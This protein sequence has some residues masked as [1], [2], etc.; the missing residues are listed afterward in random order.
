MTNKK[1]IVALVAV[2]IIAIIGV[3][4][5]QGKTVVREI[6]EVAV[7]GVSTLD[8]INHPFVKINGKSEYYYFQNMLATSSVI[9]SIRNPFSATSTL[10]RFAFQITANGLGA[11]TVDLSTSSTAFASSSPAYIRAFATGAGQSSAVWGMGAT[12]TNTSLI[13][14]AVSNNVGNS[15]NLIGPNDFINVRLATST[16]G[17]FGSYFTGTCSGVIEKL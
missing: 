12:T 10:E 6:K 13:G 3:L 14:M 15:N 9:C 17:T 1:Y 11:Q 8:G 2:L 16:P 4:T 7:G 5:P